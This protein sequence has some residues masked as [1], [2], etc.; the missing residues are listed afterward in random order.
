MSGLQEKGPRGGGSSD[1]AAERKQASETP[2]M[3]EADNTVNQFPMRVLRRTPEELR[4]IAI[5]SRAFDD[6]SLEKYTPFFWT[7]EISNNRLDSYYTRM[8]PS[9]LKNYA[10]DAKAGVAFLYSHDCTEL[11]GRSMDAK[12]TNSQGNGVAK[13]S[14]DFFAVPDLQLGS[15]S[16]NQLI[17]AIDTGVLTDVSV[18]FYGG[19]WVCSICGFDIWDWEECG[20]YPSVS[21]KVQ[22][23][24]E[25]RDEVC[26]ADVEDAHLAEVS[27][28]YKGSTPGAMIAKANRQ[29]KEG[30]MSHETRL[31]LQN[32]LRIDL[33]DKRVIVPGLKESE[34][35]ENE[36]RQITDETADQASQQAALLTDIRAIAKKAGLADDFGS[37]VEGYRAAAAELERLRPL[38]DDGNTYRND[39]IEEA[40]AEGVRA[41]GEN[42]KKEQ[43]E[44]TLR[45]STLETI[46]L[47]RDDWK[48]A[49]DKTFKG[50]RQTV[51]ST[52]DAAPP[53]KRAAPAACYEP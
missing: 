44:A 38:A 18:G 49:G 46:K 19:R 48:R 10:A 45:S 42:F 50:G 25:T 41:H 43:Y 8:A 15:V 1:S 36:N 34:M 39:L 14:A 20:H 26:T 6:E 17:R 30:N 28:V 40:L 21:F 9:S 2:L 5:E 12:F 4:Q 53:A 13:V 22:A 16:S 7:A 51:D 32:R 29:A 31:L 11:V 52:E 3:P 37:I 33:P 35:P 47:M 27:G 24:G 23:D